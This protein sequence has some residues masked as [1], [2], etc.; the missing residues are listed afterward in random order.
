[1]Y[2]IKIVQ[3]SCNSLLCNSQHETIMVALRLLVMANQDTNC[4]LYSRSIFAFFLRPS[5]I[6]I[7]R[8]KDIYF[9]ILDHP[10]CEKNDLSLSIFTFQI[11]KYIMTKW[12]IFF[13]VSYC[14]L[15]PRCDHV[16]KSSPHC[17]K[18]DLL[19]SFIASHTKL[20]KKVVLF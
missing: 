2:R 9:L 13:K 10:C 20:A 5:N 4:K 14:H 8:N 7:S 3:H 12:V 18:G 15:F 6:C 11:Y 1:M 19:L 16:W 17:H